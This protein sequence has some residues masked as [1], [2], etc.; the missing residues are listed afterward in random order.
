VNLCLTR[1][2]AGIKSKILIGYQVQGGNP[3]PGRQ[4]A[5]DGAQNQVPINGTPMEILTRKPPGPVDGD[6]E[7]L[8][9]KEIHTKAFG[10]EVHRNGPLNG[11][12]DNTHIF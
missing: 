10:P 6:L 7:N 8:M 11:V 12:E 5:F 9:P 2:S 1:N 4:S 3:F